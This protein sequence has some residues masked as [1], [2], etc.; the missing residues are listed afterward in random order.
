MLVLGG[1]CTIEL[2]T[3]LGVSTVSAKKLI[4]HALELRHRLPRLWAQ[5][6]SGRVPSWRARSISAAIAPTSVFAATSFPSRMTNV[7]AAPAAS[8]RSVGSSANASASSL[9]GMVTFDPFHA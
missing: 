6:Q 2:G 7:F 9:S 5:V 3:V 4:G 8:A 1:D